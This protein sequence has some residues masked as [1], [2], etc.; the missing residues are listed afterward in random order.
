[1]ENAGLREPAFYTFIVL[2]AI[3]IFLL[4]V[5]KQK[6]PRSLAKRAL[7]DTWNS[8]PNFVKFYEN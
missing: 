2:Q 4:P 3:N 7:Q 6:S 1:M 5:S 8:L